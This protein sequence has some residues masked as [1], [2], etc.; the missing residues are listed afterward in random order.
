[1]ILYLSSCYTLG[2]E[3]S[4]IR[5]VYTY[6]N[7]R[8]APFTQQIAIAKIFIL[9]PNQYDL[10]HYQV[11]ID[12]S[13]VLRGS[14]HLRVVDSNGNDLPSAMSRPMVSA[15]GIYLAL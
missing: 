5:L 12:L 4:P 7:I 15:R 9:N 2:Y 13:S 10:Q 6:E 1:M 11:R 3:E 14:A 8:F